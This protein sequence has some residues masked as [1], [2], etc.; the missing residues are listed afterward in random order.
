MK[1]LLFILRFLQSKLCQNSFIVLNGEIVYCSPMARRNQQFNSRLKQSQIVQRTHLV[2]VVWF[3][4]IA[5]VWTG[6][7]PILT[8]ELE[9]ERA[10]LPSLLVPTRN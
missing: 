3:N 1:S 8:S 7:F 10:I 6:F 9:S 2:P 4:F 5:T